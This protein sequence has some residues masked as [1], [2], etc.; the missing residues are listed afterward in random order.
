M[1]IVFDLDDTL[2]D[3]KTFVYSGFSEVA[4]WISLNSQE[5]FIEIFDFMVND[6]QVNG[7]GKV[8]NNTL[9]KYYIKTKKNIR[10][11]LSIYRLHR[12]NIKLSAGVEKL[13]YGLQKDYKL[14]IV[15]DGN[16]LVQNNKIMSLAVERFMEKV[17][18]TY[19]Y[20]LSA[21]KP[22]LKCFEMI[23]SREKVNWEEIIYI[24]DNPNKDFVNLNKVNAVTIRVL[25]GDYSTIK[26]DKNYDAIYKIDKIT[27]LRKILKHIC[28]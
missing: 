6:L 9:S 16:K 18:I 4:K 2:Y 11:C 17:F 10:K 3:E 21:S 24:G 22:S 28:K 12:P 8:F 1:I 5:N 27:E 25:Q 14:Y 26:V 7:R 15:T 13:L 19:R 23:K 20:G